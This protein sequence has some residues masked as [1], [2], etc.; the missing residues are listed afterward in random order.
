MIDIHSH[1]I[2]DVDDGSKTLKESI[3][4]LEQ[5]KKINL[6]KIICTPHIC[7]GNREKVLKIVNNFKIL[8]EE[9]KKLN[10]DLYLGNEIMLSDETLDL[11]KQKKITSLKQTKYL[12]VEFKR[13]ERRNIDDIINILEELVDNGYKVILA[14]PE[15]YI[16]YRNLNYIKKIKEAGIMLQMDATNILFNQSDYQTRKFAKK[17]IDERLID[18]VAS[19]C[20]CTKKRD[21]LSLKKAYKKISRTDKYYAK[22]IF[23][24]N[25]K[26][27]IEEEN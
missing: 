18:I 25:P 19:D 11:L 17:L 15:S 10:I 9:A 1:I 24:D 14:H 2:F 13:N 21:Y 7:H 8:R 12:L 6:N 5:A 27:I 23:C 3:K 22:I 16:N 4:Y 26:Y 20:H